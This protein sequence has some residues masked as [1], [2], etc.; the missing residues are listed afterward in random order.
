MHIEHVMIYVNLL[1][2]LSEFCKFETDN[3]WYTYLTQ[4][5]HI[6][7]IQRAILQSFRS[8]DKSKI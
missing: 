7:N 6:E 2:M 4:L 5:F 3:K 8:E 1:C